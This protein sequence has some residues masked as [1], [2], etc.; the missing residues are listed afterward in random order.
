MEEF[1]VLYHRPLE[2]LTAFA[3]TIDLYSQ[4]KIAALPRLPI[5]HWQQKMMLGILKEQEAAL[6][7]RRGRS[8][9]P[10]LQIILP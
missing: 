5:P 3:A 1:E 4:A 2:G 9:F 10:S 8:Y 6:C 7:F